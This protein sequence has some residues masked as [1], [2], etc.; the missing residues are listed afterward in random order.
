MPKVFIPNMVRQDLTAARQWGE[1]RFVN[2][3]YV[4]PDELQ[5]NGRLPQD[6]SRL[7]HEAAQEF[8]PYE[9]YLLIVGDHWQV[10][11]MSALLGRMYEFFKVLRWDRQAE[12]YVPATIY[13][14]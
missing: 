13:I 4:Y 3:K 12:G 14:R 11:E 8:D 5:E 6:T 2:E 7:L 10:V 9:D 1:L